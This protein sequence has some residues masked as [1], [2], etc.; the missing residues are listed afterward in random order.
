MYEA[1]HYY[2]QTDEGYNTLGWA[3]T[4]LTAAVSIMLAAYAHYNRQ[5]ERRNTCLLTAFVSPV[6]GFHLPAIIAIAFVAAGMALVY[7]TFKFLFI[8]LIP[9]KSVSKPK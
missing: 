4:V 7:F 2:L 6:I 8:T 3:C 5:T 9:Q 1:I